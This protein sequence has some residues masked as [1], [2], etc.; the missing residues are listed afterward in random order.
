MDNQKY[1]IIV[2]VAFFT[3]LFALKLLYPLAIRLRLVDRPNSRKQ[4]SGEIPLIGGVAMFIGFCAGLILILPDITNMISGVFFASL[5]I[6]T[7]GI[8]DD[9]SEISVSLRF[10]AQIASVLVMIYSGL[11]I[12]DL[13]NLLGVGVFSL[14]YFSLPFTIIAA[15]GV[16]N[17]LNMI[18]GVD[19]LAGATAIVCFISVLFL[20]YL[21]GQ[22]NIIP[23]IFTAVLVPFL[24]RNM[25]SKKKIFMGDAGSMFLGLGLVWSVISASQGEDAVMK[26]VTALW[27]LAIPLM[28]TIV[29]ML[30][31]MMHGQSP[32]SPDREHLHHILIKIGFNN[33]ETLHIM[34]LITI[35]FSLIGVLGQAFN[36]PEWVMF[37]AFIILCFTYLFLVHRIWLGIKLI[38]LNEPELAATVNIPKLDT[39]GDDSSEVYEAC[40][41]CGKLTYELKS[42]HIDYRDRYVIGVGQVCGNCRL[43]K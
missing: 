7:I 5:I 43:K 17:A 24:W 3:S 21:S 37:Y 6:V 2:S 23:L 8:L 34:T 1:Y 14:G 39:K 16:I 35:I 18:D 10:I 36:V 38:K 9:Y 42:T 26:P 11:Q 40:V 31:R 15:V 20:Y 22:M 28:D 29:T 25:R 30:R 12:S 33:K 13:G 19:G 4:H 41:V 32:F 27:I